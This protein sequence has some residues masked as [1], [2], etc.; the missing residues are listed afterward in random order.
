MTNVPHDD[1][2]S[3]LNAICIIKQMLSG[4]TNLIAG[5][6]FLCRYRHE[7]DVDDGA[8]WNPII[9]FESETDDYP[10]GELRQK[11]SSAYLQRLDA[12]IVSYIDESTPIIFECCEKLLTA[13]ARNSGSKI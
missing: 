6:R 2:L 9:G 5:C 1:S 13:L 8:I 10:L 3:T 7:C 12:E 11:Y 4:E